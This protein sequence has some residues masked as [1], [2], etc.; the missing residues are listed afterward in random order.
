MKGKGKGKAPLGKGKGSSKGP[1]GI[2]GQYDSLSFP[3]LNSMEAPDQ[4]NYVENWNEDSHQGQ[5]C[6]AWGPLMSLN[7]TAD[8]TNGGVDRVTSSSEEGYRPAKSRKK[9]KF[10]KSAILDEQLHEAKSYVGGNRFAAL[11]ES[12]AHRNVASYPPPQLANEKAK[13]DVVGVFKEVKRVVEEEKKRVSMLT[14][15]DKAIGGVKSPLEN[16]WK[17]LSLAVDSGAFTTVLHPDELPNYSVTE[18]EGSRAGEEFTAA[19]GDS[20]PNLG[21]MQI[22]IVTRERTQRTLNITAAPVTKGL[23]AVKQLNQTGHC[24]VFDEG[25]SFIL[26]KATGEMNLL[27]E[28]NGNFMLDLWVPPNSSS[29]FQ[30]QP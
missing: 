23:L 4:W 29:G 2:L 3:P 6:Q 7:K 9:L 21:A 20:I 8:S 28:E 11:S 16:G 18:T 14:K 17:S 15:L 10:G 22:P 24:V 19:S 13:K 27:R 30:G 26:N 1:M 12:D 5:Q 25:H